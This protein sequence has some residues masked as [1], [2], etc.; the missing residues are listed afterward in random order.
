LFAAVRELARNENCTLFTV[1]LVALNILLYLST[2]ETDIRIGTLV[3]NRTRRETERVIGYFINTVI[4][5]TKL[6]PEMTVKET[7]R[8]VR[9]VAVE[10]YVHQELPY[11]RLARLQE[12]R[13]LT[14]A[15]LCQVLFNY[16]SLTSLPQSLAGLAFATWD[17]P[18]GNDVAE[19]T[20]TTFDLIFALREASTKLTGTVN[21]KTNT[22]GKRNVTIMIEAF[23]GIL[24]SMVTSPIQPI[25]RLSA[26]IR[27]QWLRRR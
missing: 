26:D 9:D 15:S 22:F 23:S 25:S 24:R 6:C 2:G 3:A 21:Y 27:A 7:L 20:P 8:S 18:Y 10:A 16:Q 1:L 13:K 12:E 14:R 5:R 19:L 11:E 17:L 4:L